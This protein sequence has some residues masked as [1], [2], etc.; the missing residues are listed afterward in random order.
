MIG[1]SNRFYHIIIFGGVQIM[2][3][4]KSFSSVSR[5]FPTYVQIPSEEYCRKASTY[6]VSVIW[7][8]EENVERETFLQI[9]LF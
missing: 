3:L 6:G 1:P 9:M 4:I 5:Y 2:N 8:N 7:Q